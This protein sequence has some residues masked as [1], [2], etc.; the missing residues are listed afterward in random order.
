MLTTYTALKSVHVLAAIVW[1]GGATTVQ[2][3]A[4]RANRAHEPGAFAKLL[5]DIEFVGSRVFLPSS[6]IL[7]VAGFGMVADGDL[8]FELWLVLGT[9]VWALSAATGAAFLGPESGRIGKIFETEGMDS[10][11]A[12]ARTKRIFL[13]SRIE[14]VLLILIVLDMVMKPGT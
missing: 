5:G 3:F 12:V 7:V 1:I 4:I 9:I 6:L 2:I 14:L 11:A 8:D 13:I 10:P